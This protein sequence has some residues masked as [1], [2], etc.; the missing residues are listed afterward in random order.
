MWPFKSKKNQEYLE[1]SMH[2]YTVNTCKE[3]KEY[4]KQLK[5]STLEIKV[6]APNTTNIDAVLEDINMKIRAF[7]SP[8]LI[9]DMSACGYMVCISPT[10]SLHIK[11]YISEFFNYSD[12]YEFSV[13]IGM[14]TISYINPKIVCIDLGINM[15]DSFNPPYKP[16]FEVK[17]NLAGIK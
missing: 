13:K 1:A 6:S 10:T 9:A 14:I 17:V 16:P 11:K 4:M 12:L 8:T 2:E 15:K 5:G 7:I 3:I